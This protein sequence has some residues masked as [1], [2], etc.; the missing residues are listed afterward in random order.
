M[1]VC[2]I[3]FLLS[4]GVGFL[5][6]R[7]GATGNAILAGFPFEKGDSWI[8]QGKVAWQVPDSEE[9]R[10]KSLTWVVS[11]QESWENNNLKAALMKGFVT[12]LAF[13]EEGKKPGEYLLL[14]AGDIYYFL[15]YPERSPELWKR[16]NDPNDPLVGLVSDDELFL[17]LP[18]FP[19]KIFGET[20]QITRNDS[21]YVWV[22]QEVTTKTFPLVKGLVP[23]HPYE[24]YHLVYQ[25]SPDRTDY[26]FVPG[27][28]ITRY[29]YLHHGT[30]SEVDI[31]L[32]EYR[33]SHHTK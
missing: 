10:E 29:V 13:Y 26:Y 2:F 4:M 3:F 12:D 18:L 8:Y 28:G 11:V 14:R 9:K 24:E 16:I 22:V 23:N 6:S 17:E 30:L 7:A 33:S 19:E 25:T 15:I 21:M 20:D 5:S 27:V 31:R 1:H 32:V